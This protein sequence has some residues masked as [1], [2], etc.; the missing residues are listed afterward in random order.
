MISIVYSTMGSY[1]EACQIA[2]TLVDHKLV[3]CAN[4]IP[5]ITSIY[6]WKGSIEEDSE[7]VL[8]AKT[9]E[10][11]VDEVIQKIRSLHSYEVP[12]IIVI[13]VI[14]GLNDYISYV[15]HETV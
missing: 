1:E 4:I 8:L 10:K 13:P 15:E 11:K 7:C 5:S 6:R 12:D 9:S 2:R 3:A 14:T